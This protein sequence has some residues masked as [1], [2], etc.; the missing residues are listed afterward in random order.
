MEKSPRKLLFWTFALVG[1]AALLCFLL[2]GI[3]EPTSSVGAQSFRSLQ[4]WPDRSVGVACGLLG[5]ATAHATAQVLPLGACRTVEGDAVHARTYLHFPLDVF[6]PGTEI[7]R[8]TLYM[9]V[10]SG[11]DT[12]EATFG[13][14]R[15]LESWEGADDDWEADPMSWPALLNLPLAATTVR[16]DVLTPTLPVTVATV[17]P[18]PT[19]ELTLTPTA[20]PTLTTTPTPTPL[21]SPLL[22]PTP[23]P[24]LIPTPSP[25]PPA[26]VVPLGQVTGTWLV[27]DVTALMRAWLDGEVPNDG[28][29]LASAPD[30]AA[31]PETV[32]NLLVARWLAAA[33][34]NTRPHIIAEFE[35]H[36]VTPTPPPSP[37][38]TPA[39][40]LPPAG[41]P[42][43]WEAGGI[44]FAGLA[45]L[46]L[47]LMVWRKWELR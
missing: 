25:A 41:N 6:P 2:D 19:P 36:P 16:F 34:S 40:I 20:T 10:D 1:M 23:E 44:L 26:P 33:D 17:T 45:L 38:P 29:A 12:G 9:Y 31:D 39:P 42:M 30:P 7:L 5:V 21:T 27:W 24:T 4:V 43:G 35:V 13:I 22:T 47:G 14:Y 32:D 8:A 37:L 28:L 46:V 18:S 11:S 15:A 3:A